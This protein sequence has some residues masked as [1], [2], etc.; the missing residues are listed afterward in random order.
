MK[1][2]AEL[3]PELINR[4]NDLTVEGEAEDYV[5]SLDGVIRFILINSMDNLSRQEKETLI[6][7]HPTQ[8]IFCLFAC[9]ISN[10][11]FIYTF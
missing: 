2:Q 8:K 3:T 11:C 10:Q 7:F 1:L 6:L 4:I 5:R 9:K